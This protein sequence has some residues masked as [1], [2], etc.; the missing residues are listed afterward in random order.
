M[1]HNYV[2]IS[3]CFLGA[4]TLCLL[5]NQNENFF[6]THTLS[7]GYFIQVMLHIM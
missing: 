5:G 1:A 6:C 3:L 7:L 4:D 2:T